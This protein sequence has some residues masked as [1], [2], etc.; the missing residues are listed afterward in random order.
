MANIPLPRL[1]AL[2]IARRRLTHDGR[3][4]SAADTRRYVQTAL[5]NNDDRP[6]YRPR[7]NA[8]ES[9][10]TTDI[11]LG[12]T[13]I[14]Y[15]LQNYRF[16]MHTGGLISL[17]TPQGPRIRATNNYL[18]R[19]E[20]DGVQN[21]PPIFT[22]V[23]SA[24]IGER[25]RENIG[26]RGRRYRA[27]EGYIV[28]LD[29][30]NLVLQGGVPFIVTELLRDAAGNINQELEDEFGQ[31][32]HEG[33]YLNIDVYILLPQEGVSSEKVIRIHQNRYG[34]IEEINQFWVTAKNI[35]MMA[36]QSGELDGLTEFSL[37]ATFQFIRP[38]Y[39]APLPDETSLNAARGAFN[40]FTGANL[41]RLGFNQPV[42]SQ[43]YKQRCD[44]IGKH[45]GLTNMF[46]KSKAILEVPPTES[47][48]CFPMAFV[49]SEMRK[50]E[51]TGDK[52]TGILIPKPTSAQ[53]EINTFIA[54]GMIDTIAVQE[55]MPFLNL[56][57]SLYSAIPNREIILHNTY[58]PFNANEK[59]EPNA[60]DWL[61][62]GMA[63]HAYVEDIV[64]ESV[65]VNNLYASGQA[66]ANV[67]KIHLV[68][69]STHN[70]RKRYLH[71]SPETGPYR[72]DGNIYLVPILL[73]DDHCHAITSWSLF[74]KPPT[75]AN[76]VNAYTFCPFCD[77]V[78]T[79]NNC[80]KSQG[81]EH[82]N[83]C[84]GIHKKGETSQ[85]KLLQQNAPVRFGYRKP[86]GPEQNKPW[87]LYC[88]VCHISVKKE[89]TGFHKCFMRNDVKIEVC[90]EQSL[91]V[92]DIEASQMSAKVGHPAYHHC[93]LVCAQ[94]MYPDNQGEY[95]KN[96]WD[97]FESF[98]MEILS[99]KKY[100]KSK[101]L[102]HNGGKY[103]MNFLVQYLEKEG[104]EYTFIPS[105]GSIHRYMSLTIESLNIV[106][107]DFIYFCPGSLRQIAKSFGLPTEKGHFPHLFNRGDNLEYRG[108]APPLYGPEGEDYWMLRTCRKQED[109]SDII[110]F[111]ES[112][113]NKH[114]ECQV[115]PN[116]SSK[117]CSVCLR[118]YWI[119]REKLLYYCEIDVHVLAL[120]CDK[121]RSTMMEITRGGNHT[122]ESWSPQSIDPF[123]LLTIAQVAL[124]TLLKGHVNY[125]LANIHENERYGRV[126]NATI[127]LNQLSGNII[128]RGNSMQEYY[129]HDLNLTFDGY[130]PDTGEVYLLLDC[131]AYACPTC[132]DHVTPRS[133]AHPIRGISFGKIRMEGQRLIARV[134]SKYKAK[135][136]IHWKHEIILPV[137]PEIRERWRDYFY[138]GRTEVFSPYANEDKLGEKIAYH[139]VCSLYPHVCANET[140]PLGH[141]ILIPQDQVELERLHPTHPDRYFGFVCCFV[142][143]ASGDI[144]G[145]LPQR[146]ES[147]RLQF[148]IKPKAGC[149]STE[150]LYLAMEN[151]YRVSDIYEV[152]H[153]SRHQQTNEMMRGYIGMFLRMKQEA[154]GWKKLGASSDTPS[155]VEMQE[156]I[157]RVEE[158]S[159]FVCRVRK[160]FVKK[161]PV[162][163]ALAKLFL[164]TL[165][166]KFAQ[167]TEVTKVTTIYSYSDFM[168]IWNNPSVKREN[169]QF[170]EIGNRVFQCQYKN[171]EGY[172]HRSNRTNIF[173]AA[174]V[175]SKARCIL[176]RQML[177]VGPERILYCDTDSII[178]HHPN[179]EQWVGNGLGQW[180]DEL[181]GQSITEFFAIAP[182]FYLMKIGDKEEVKAKG[183]ML[184]LNNQEKL[185][186]NEMIKLLEPYWNKENYQ[187]GV[188]P[189]ILL[190]NTRISSNKKQKIGSAYGALYTEIGD[191]SVRC[192]FSK[193]AVISIQ[194]DNLENCDKL[195]SRPFSQFD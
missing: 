55:D 169:L 118:P 183:V 91:Y 30:N 48:F 98:I 47:G 133:T 35:L 151:G 144:L 86:K 136:H 121:Y 41:R 25:E 188:E 65:D 190:D 109:R 56:Y 57:D 95:W 90:D 159:Q 68:V 168:E 119:L 87:E 186:R 142:Y 163:R 76:S 150:E 193:R 15:V 160:E 94:S 20:Y 146:E 189:S 141:P 187:G 72:E 77:S 185:R 71:F 148:D 58:V 85:D 104:I 127:W 117:N 84:T 126:K 88:M 179:P 5:G 69:Y 113:K 1:P 97:T 27:E 138:G 106:F 174:M 172:T 83:K 164:N 31:I 101:W 124:T 17:S 122:G 70:M 108:P 171:I 89:E 134:R 44:K 96:H 42:G 38:N 149:W 173:I 4:I 115:P 18:R 152:I 12:F 53:R 166:G 22:T 79:S 21:A 123:S 116:Q 50:V 34:S 73:E 75:S 39:N 40:P 130:N 80:S 102:S 8:L 32:N 143:P 100:R 154:E 43:T 140:L 191:K 181:D 45:L 62:A 177:K 184:T 139:D 128:H 13:P 24:E 162:Q 103:D 180:T 182:K 81:L 195:R 178:F 176:H 145:L 74:M 66:Y 78:R 26:R 61:I 105:P 111:V 60:E 59:C 153:W 157:Q 49:R 64:G 67:F 7:N 63:T 11:G 99:D 2:T 54:N 125:T 165:W 112:E 29:D 194:I 175:T 46:F 16:G 14:T 161:N 10:Y 192:V 137:E 37:Q 156:V 28:P 167:R 158:E 129:D 114:C 51:R 23:L 92:F 36:F 3:A 155:E 147:G 19:R 170:R 93:N 33:T 52:I 110:Q 132:H 135:A 9:T 107:Q 120:A 131:L 6:L 82:M